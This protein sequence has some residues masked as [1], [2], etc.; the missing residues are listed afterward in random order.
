VLSF[1]FVLRWRGVWY[2][3]FYGEYFFLLNKL[4]L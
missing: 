3:R 1:I 4:I 2:S